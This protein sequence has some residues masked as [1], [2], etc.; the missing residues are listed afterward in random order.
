MLIGVAWSICWFNS[1]STSFGAPTGFEE[2]RVFL[3]NGLGSAIRDVYNPADDQS[4]S[5]GKYSPYWFVA[6]TCRPVALVP[7]Q[8]ESF[9]SAS[10]ALFVLSRDFSLESVCILLSSIT[11]R[12]SYKHSNLPLDSH[13]FEWVGRIAGAGCVEFGLVALHMYIQV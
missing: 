13:K 5:G 9:A 2:E 3:S 7:A 10:E 11:R 8:W 6:S 1:D 12:D 4:D